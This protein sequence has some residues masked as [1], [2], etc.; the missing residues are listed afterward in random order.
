MNAIVA[1]ASTRPASRTV[2]YGWSSSSEMVTVVSDHGRSAGAPVH[3]ARAWSLNVSGP[4]ARSSSWTLAASARPFCTVKLSSTCSAGSSRGLVTAV[5]TSSGPAVSPSPPAAARN[6][7]VSGSQNGRSTLRVT[8]YPYC[9]SETS[10]R[11]SRVSP[12]GIASRPS[13][14]S[15]VRQT[16]EM[17]C[18]VD[19]AVPQNRRYSSHSSSA[20]SPHPTVT[21]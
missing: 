15:P 19:A 8:A 4:S 10:L 18:T 12:T 20:Q 5:T 11:P 21:R 1:P 3:E 13:R 14:S 17:V 9:D 16:E 7:T 6:W 2:R